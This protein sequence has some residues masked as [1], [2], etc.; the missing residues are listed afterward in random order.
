MET[1]SKSKLLPGLLV[2]LVATLICLTTIPPPKVHADWNNATYQTSFFNPFDNISV[3]VSSS[4]SSGIVV[5]PFTELNAA[6]IVTNSFSVGYTSDYTEFYYDY[7]VQNGTTF[8]FHI[9]NI[10]VSKVGLENFWE[11]FY[12]E[13][14]YD[15]GYTSSLQVAFQWLTNSYTLDTD[16]YLTDLSDF[17]GGYYLADTFPDFYIPNHLTRTYNDV[18]YVYI[19]DFSMLFRN[20]LSGGGSYT[21]TI[22]FPYVE[23]DCLYVDYLNAQ[24]ILTVESFTDLN[25]DIDIF[26]TLFS[27]VRNFL[28]I[29]ILP[30]F[31]FADILAFALTVPLVIWLLKAW[32]GG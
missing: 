5:L 25:T 7:G 26:D 31:S 2:V 21:N 15:G 23:N 1:K 16:V 17:Q 14:E 29:E 3:V 19:A 13:I 10:W 12:Y 9:T 27:S 30:N 8:G 4:E 18:D 32:L 24:R 28:S 11:Q 20:T 22:F 6:N